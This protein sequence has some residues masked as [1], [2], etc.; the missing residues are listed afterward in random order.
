MCMQD[1]HALDTNQVHHIGVCAIPIDAH[2]LGLQHT[3]QMRLR[4]DG[5]DISEIEPVR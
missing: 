3:G 4:T 2:A 1:K 5:R